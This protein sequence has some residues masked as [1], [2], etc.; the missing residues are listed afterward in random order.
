M[1]TKA[2]TPPKFWVE[3]DFNGEKF[4]TGTVGEFIVRQVEM[5]KDWHSLATTMQDLEGLNGAA[6]MRQALINQINDWAGRAT[7]RSIE[8]RKNGG[9]RKETDTKKQ[10]VIR[11]LAEY[12]SRGLPPRDIAAK[13]ASK[14]KCSAQ[15]IRQIRLEL[16][17]RN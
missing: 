17:K 4:R 2:K 16:K 15:Y 5:A 9:I 14:A 13:V 8:G 12:E 7:H 10:L 6:K 3:W 1:P 11:L